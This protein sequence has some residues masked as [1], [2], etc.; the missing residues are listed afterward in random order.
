MARLSEAQ[1]V[2]GDAE[3]RAI[4]GALIRE[5]VARRYDMYYVPI[6]PRLVIVRRE[7]AR[8]VFPQT[9]VMSQSAVHLTGTS[10][11]CFK[12]SENATGLVIVLVLCLISFRN[13]VHVE[14]VVQE[15]RLNPSLNVIMDTSYSPLV[16]S[17]QAHQ[18]RDPLSAE[19]SG[20]DRHSGSLMS[21]QILMLL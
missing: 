14:A 12:P 15:S 4:P 18:E 5:I 17:I 6:G 2:N 8:K 11:S 21:G 10:F 19:R 20:A 7:E 1:T 16:P 13:D 9:I 3:D